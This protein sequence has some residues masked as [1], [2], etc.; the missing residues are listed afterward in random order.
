M[1]PDAAAG[2][3]PRDLTL[4]EA[5]KLAMANV[6][7]K[8]ETVKAD[9]WESILLLRARVRTLE[10]DLRAQVGSED[11]EDDE[12]EEDEEDEEEED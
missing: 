4:V 11:D 9:F 2:T 7:S 12:E 3:P 10:Q 1:P 5:I 6:E 8:V